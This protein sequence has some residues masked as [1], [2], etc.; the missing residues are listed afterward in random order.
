MMLNFVKIYA[1]EA[2][3]SEGHKSIS[4]CNIHLC[5]PTLIKFS[6][7]YMHVMQLNILEFC[8]GWHWVTILFFWEERITFRLP[9]YQETIWHFESKGSLDK[10]CVPHHAVH[11][12]WF[13]FQVIKLALGLTQPC[14]YS[15]QGLFPRSRGD[16]S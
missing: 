8:E 9:M 5:G 4:A 11:N 14:S 6:V 15:V 12:L 1:V 10:I 2:I 3:L 7:R 16:D 13:I